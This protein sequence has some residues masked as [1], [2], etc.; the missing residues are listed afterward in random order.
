[1]HVI[2]PVFGHT[3]VDSADKF[4]LPTDQAPDRTH[5]LGVERH[6]ALRRC[7]IRLF[8]SWRLI[9]GDGMGSSVSIRCTPR[10]GP[11][12]VLGIHIIRRLV[13]R[14]RLTGKQTADPGPRRPL[15][16]FH[17]PT[18]IETAKRKATTRDADHGDPDLRCAGD[19]APGIHGPD[20]IDP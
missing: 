1:M 18:P 10:N 14:R 7:R 15:R 5:A 16:A 2:P 3:L 17:H 6:P 20:L 9:A 8:R 12:G 4:L 11:H 13:V 19:G